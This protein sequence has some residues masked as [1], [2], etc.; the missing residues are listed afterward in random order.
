MK[1]M[2]KKSKW[3]HKTPNNT[4]SISMTFLF[5]SLHI[6]LILY[7]DPHLIS[8][9]PLPAHTSSLIN[10]TFLEI[11]WPYL[12]KYQVSKGRRYLTLL[13]FLAFSIIP[14]QSRPLTDVCW[15]KAYYHIALMRWQSCYS[16]VSQNIWLTFKVLSY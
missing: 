7:L 9:P 3:T 4:S 14:R 1:A 8:H 11:S 6:V 13:V 2:R 10:P 12:E 5:Q 15:I 16:I